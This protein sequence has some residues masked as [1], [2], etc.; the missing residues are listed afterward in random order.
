MIKNNVILS[1]TLLCLIKKV[2]TFTKI[3]KVYA[4]SKKEMCVFST[5]KGVDGG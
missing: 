2:V 4:F 3:L 1:N 5:W